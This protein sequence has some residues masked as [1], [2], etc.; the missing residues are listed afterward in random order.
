VIL[1]NMSGHGHLNDVGLHQL[2]P[3]G[4][5][6][7][8]A[9]DEAGPRHGARRPARALPP[10]WRKRRRVGKGAKAPRLNTIGIFA[11]GFAALAPPY[12]RA[13]AIPK[14]RGIDEE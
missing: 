9:Y 11:L 3:K 1:F 12:A 14:Y 2:F 10:D 7:D 4:N 5:L 13:S 8:Q 6:V